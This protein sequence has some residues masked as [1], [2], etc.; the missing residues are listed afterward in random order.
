MLISISE[1]VSQGTQPE[2]L[3]LPKTM[4]S[5]K[6]MI[7]VKGLSPGTIWRKNIPRRENKFKGPAAE[8]GLLCLRKSR[9]AWTS[10]QLNTC[11]S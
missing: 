4:T 1:S 5:S 8:V 10:C 7:C 11:Y 3:G 9:M 6:D 2:T